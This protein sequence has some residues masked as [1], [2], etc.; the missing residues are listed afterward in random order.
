MSV[1]PPQPLANRRKLAGSPHPARTGV[2][3]EEFNLTVDDQSLTEVL[4]KHLHLLGRGL[5]DGEPVLRED[6]TMGIVDGSWT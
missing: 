3:G 6:G 4:R 1:F 5:G 2:F